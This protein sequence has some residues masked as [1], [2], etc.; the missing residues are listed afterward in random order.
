MST[1]LYVGNLSFDTNDADL[2]TAFAAC[3]S[4]TDVAIVQDKMTGRSRGFGFVTMSSAEEAQA[5]ISQFHGKDFDG[6]SLTVN[7]ARPREDFGP[8][9]PRKSFGGGNKGGGDRDRRPSTRRY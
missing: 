3:G 8:S 1:K 2:R 9:A 4:V 7:E 5:A 6:R